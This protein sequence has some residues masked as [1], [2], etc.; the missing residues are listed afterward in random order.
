[1]EISLA[2]PVRGGYVIQMFGCDK[3]YGTGPINYASLGFAG[4]SGL[5]YTGCE[6]GIYAAHTGTIKAGWDNTGY[7]NCAIITDKSGKWSTLYGHMSKL[8]ITSGPVN[9]GDKIGIIGATGNADGVHLH[10]E[11]RIIGTNDPAWHGR[12]DPVPFRE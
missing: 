1:M 6:D 3:R 11:L 9:A 8:L 10:F 7:G 12:I 4:H 5:D 2:R